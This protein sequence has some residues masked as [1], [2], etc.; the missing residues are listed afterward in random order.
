MA[1]RNLQIVQM[2]GCLIIVSDLF[3]IAILNEYSKY[4]K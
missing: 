3:A 2:Y 4:E 1:S